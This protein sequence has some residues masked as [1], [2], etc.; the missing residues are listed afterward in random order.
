MSEEASPNAPTTGPRTRPP[1]PYSC[2]VLANGPRS[3]NCVL[4]SRVSRRRAVAFFGFPQLVVRHS[5]Y[6]FGGV[7]LVVGEVEASDMLRVEQR[8]YAKATRCTLF[9][10]RP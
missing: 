2:R 5:N 8:C 3:L 9:E 1:L 7:L 10:A 4:W 6:A